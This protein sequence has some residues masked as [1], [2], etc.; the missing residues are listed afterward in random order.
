ML[1]IVSG[2]LIILL[3]ISFAFGEVLIV[4]DTDPRI[5]YTGPWARISNHTAANNTQGFNNT[6]TLCKNATGD[7]QASFSFVG[8]Q[9]AVYGARG[10]PGVWLENSTYSVDNGPVSAWVRDDNIPAIDYNVSFYSSAALQ[11]ATHS[12]QVTNHGEWFFLDRLQVTVP[13]LSS[14]NSV[15]G[16]PTSSPGGPPPATQSAGTASG[17]S[18]STESLSKGALVGIVIGAVIASACISLAIWRLWRRRTRRNGPSDPTWR[19]EPFLREDDSQPYGSTVL[20]GTPTAAIG[21]NVVS[22]SYEP[23][24]TGET[25]RDTSSLLQNH[26]STTEKRAGAQLRLNGKTSRVTQEMRE[27]AP[28]SNPDSH[29]DDSMSLPPAYTEQE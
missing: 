12:L 9:I 17:S 29:I 18:P 24:N 10:P 14:P 4:D 15:A 3:N 19:A 5:V 13:D 21:V 11:D 7:C 27:R 28:T 26:R 2:A 8:T 6:L 23:T 20:S 1:S 25:A 16:T 22:E